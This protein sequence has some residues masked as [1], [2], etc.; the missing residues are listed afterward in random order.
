[1]GNANS[2]EKSRIL[3]VGVSYIINL[4]QA[5]PYSIMRG[6]EFEVAILC[7]ARWKFREWSR[8]FELETGIESILYFPAKIVFFN[9]RVGAYLYPLGTFLKS[10]KEFRPDLIYVE[11][12]VFSLSAFQAAIISR[13]FDIPLA[14]FCWENIDRRLSFIRQWTRRFVLHTAKLITP[15]NS[16]ALELLGKWGYRGAAKVIPQ[17]GVDTT[18]FSPKRKG[19]RNKPFSVGFVGRLVPEKGIDLLL[20]AAAEVIK[21]GCHC[22]VIICGVGPV[23]ASL[24]HE[25]KKL[26]LSGVVQW[27]GEYQYEDVPS[28]IAQMDV[29]VLPSR[30]IP[31]IW[32]E[33]FGHVLIEAMAMGVPVLG[34]SSGAIPEVIGREDLIFTEEDAG[35]LAEKLEILMTNP[36][37]YAQVVNYCR[38]TVAERFTHE[39]IAEQLSELFRRAVM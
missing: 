5:K 34:S 11:Q 18:V 32:M 27:L 9:G 15:G 14:V 38:S 31:G 16:R 13:I 20:A 35:S 29:L 1:M 8:V 19:H 12:E 17:L 36:D 30:T 22:R 26:G 3:F 2:R 10:I 39:R 37:Y 28:A 21:R 6:G 23:E 24:H 7:P 33:Q 25:A 4:Y